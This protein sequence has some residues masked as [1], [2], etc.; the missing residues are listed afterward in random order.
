MAT[1]SIMGESCLVGGAAFAAKSKPPVITEHFTRL[2]CNKDTTIGMEG[3]AETQLLELDRRVNEEVALIFSQMP[4]RAQKLDFSAAENAWFAYR[5]SDCQ[6]FAAIYENGTF[7][8]VEYALCEVRND[9]LRS[10]DLHSLYDQL[11]QGSENP[12]G[13]P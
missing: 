10:S 5:G 12:P 3:C 2:P 11:H 7:G 4:T 13:W 6:S 9:Q 1:A 8:P